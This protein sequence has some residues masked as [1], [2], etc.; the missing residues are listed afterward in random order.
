M[1]KLTTIADPQLQQDAE[2]L[3]EALGDLIRVYQFRDRDRICCHDLSITQ[4]HAL[5]VLS[6]RGGLSLNEVAAELYLDKSTTSRV[7]AA[8]ERKGYVERT[9]HPE[10]RRAILL[11]VTGA[12][13]ALYKRIH[14]AIIEQEKGLLTDFDS[15]TRQ[16]MTKLIHR[17][18]AAAAER[19]EASGGSC[20]VKPISID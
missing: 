16:S 10:D 4:C 7:V 11:E 14:S 9:E 13:Q 20:C 19:V 8:L 12:G 5:E 2:A 1:T 17:L 15:G 18:A 3:Y 6:M